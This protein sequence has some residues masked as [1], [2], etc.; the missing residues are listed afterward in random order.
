QLEGILRED[1]AH[2]PCDKTLPRPGASAWAGRDVRTR[3]GLHRERSTIRHG[4]AEFRRGESDK[5]RGMGPDL[6]ATHTTLPVPKSAPGRGEDRKFRRT[7]RLR[8]SK[9]SR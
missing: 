7:L 6:A 9:C 5:V 2:R 8:C 3:F 1:D 4:A